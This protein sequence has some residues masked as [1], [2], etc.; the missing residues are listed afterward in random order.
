MSSAS[1]FHV[2]RAFHPYAESLTVY[3][4]DNFHR[5]NDR[6]VIAR[7]ILRAVGCSALCLSMVASALFAFWTCIRAELDLRARV[8]HIA[9]TVCGV[10]QFFVFVSMTRNNHKILN[11]LER[12]QRT[13]NNGKRSKY[14]FVAFT[15][16][17]YKKNDKT[18]I[19][20]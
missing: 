3:N 16:F 15:H 18:S 19:L 4:A 13:V 8:Y 7:N 20:E 14:I 1:K 11:V 12:L 9:T 5:A 17:T 10:Q 2:L 6:C